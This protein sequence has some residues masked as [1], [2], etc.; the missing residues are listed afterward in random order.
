MIQQGRL[1]MTCPFQFLL[2]EWNRTDNHQK[3]LILNYFK[4]RPFSAFHTQHFNI[5]LFHHSIR[6][7]QEDGRINNQNFKVL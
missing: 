7:M 2:A 1:S 4:I 3:M 5:P 6:L